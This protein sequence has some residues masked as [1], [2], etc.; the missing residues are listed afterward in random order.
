MIKE[1]VVERFLGYV[2]EYT[3]SD[4]KSTT[5]PTTDRQMVFAKKIVKEL[6]QI[7][8]Q[9]VDLDD[10]GYIMA[11][12]PANTDKDLPV[13]GF[14]AHMDTSPDFSGE[15]VNPR[16]VEDYD[17][18]DIVLNEESNIVL[19]P[20][21]F[22]EILAYKGETLI[23]TDG[24]TLLGADDK[25]G[26]AEIITAMDYLIKHPEIEHGKI[27]IGF[28]PDEEVGRG[29]DFFDVKKF[30]AEYAYTID[31]GELGELQFENFNAAYAKVTFN[32]RSVH[33]GYAKDKMI[34]SMLLATKFANELPENEIPQETS[35]YEGFFHL[36]SM[37]GSVENSTLEYIIRDFDKEKYEQRKQLISDIADKFKTKYGDSS[38]TLELK[39][40]YFNM[41][42]K[43]EPVMH[44]VDVAKKAMEE[45]D[46]K[47]HIIPIRGGT[48]GA[49]LSFMGL[50]C[51]NIF[52]GGHNFHG[53]FEFIPVN[54]ME[55]AVNV[56]LKIVELVAK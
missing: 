46:V 18:N 17:G 42:E 9:D 51:P 29:A 8:L 49:R 53:K 21:D 55:K 19:S 22:P 45:V 20:T 50:P 38:L 25:A 41:R 35:G 12:L 5:V 15:N 44:V 39:D 6:E 27:R 33:P 28:T 56:I 1:N 7:G 34:N 32:G 14:V 52:G 2:K 10:N 40:Q 54:S 3:T 37:E 11:T 47:P 48:D 43:V 30:G 4:P 31:G 23:V 24:T 36:I 16:F 13:I 26:M